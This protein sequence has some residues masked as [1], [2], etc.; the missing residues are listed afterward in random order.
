MNTTQNETHAMQPAVE[1]S[2]LSLTRSGRPLFTDLGFSLMAGS[3]LI[4]QGSNGSGKTSL[5]KI[6]CG[7][8][9]VEKGEI[10]YNK[11][12]IEFTLRKTNNILY[13]GHKNGNNL[14][15]TVYQQL[16][17]WQKLKGEAELF[18][19]A[20]EYFD[21]WPFLDT[22][23]SELSAGWQR[24]V[25]LARMI[26]IPSTIWLLDEPMSNMDSE[27]TR[28]IQSLVQSRTEQGGVVIMSTHGFIANKDI[29][30]LNINDFN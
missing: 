5:L 9:P 24:R 15:F 16:T 26:L 28:L 14:D 1:C 2:N 30:T 25:A 23:I 21:L 8:V 7:I 29:K 20:V 10:L 27:G 17:F 11:N 13:I 12:S 3:L 6:L 4:I 18:D 22:R 19:A